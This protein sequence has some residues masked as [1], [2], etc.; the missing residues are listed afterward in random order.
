VLDNIFG[1]I[2]A[3]SCV[4]ATT[5]QERV[6]EEGRKYRCT[7]DDAAYA[8][9]ELEGGIFATFNSS[10]SVRVRRD[11]LLSIQ[12][13]G[14]EG[15]AAVSLRQVYIQPAA[16]TPKPVWNPDAAEETDYFSDWTLMP[17]TMEYDNAFKAQWELFL[18]HVVCDTPFRWSLKEGAKGVQLAEKAIE[19]WGKRA[20]VNL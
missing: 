16:G 9:F 13:D 12:V 18:K 7:A 3:V 6:D 19:S 4:A 11:D 15:S 10:W 8:M 20:W 1:E 5:I 14:T 17:D 2:K